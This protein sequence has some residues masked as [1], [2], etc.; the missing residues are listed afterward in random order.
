MLFAGKPAKR[1]LIWRK[2]MNLHGIGMVAVVSLAIFA[3]P[4]LACSHQQNVQ[5]STVVTTSDAGQP[6]TTTTTTVKKTTG[7]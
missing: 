1:R 4:A 6:A 3:G 2:T 5:A 7:G